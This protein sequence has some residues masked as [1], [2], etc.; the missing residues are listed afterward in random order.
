MKSITG[1]W[2]LLSLELKK[3]TGETVYPFGKEVKGLLLYQR[4]GYMSGIISGE[5]RP[6]VSVPATMGIPENERL[7]ISKNFIA[8]AGKY[9]TEGHKIIHAVEVSFIPNLT[10][11]SSHAGTFSFINNKLC[12]TSEQGSGSNNEFLIKVTWEKVLANDNHQT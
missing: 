10:G 1:T 5:G 2:R 8:Y 4:D 11:S 9:H 12:I 6:H 7:A 3:K